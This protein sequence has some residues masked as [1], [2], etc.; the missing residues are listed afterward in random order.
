MV[1]IAVMIESNKISNPRFAVTEMLQVT[2]H[3]KG[4]FLRNGF[5]KYR[6]ISQIV[7]HLNLKYP[8]PELSSLVQIL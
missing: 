1:K 7:F 8:V 2:N 4:K 3:V 5:Q 6:H